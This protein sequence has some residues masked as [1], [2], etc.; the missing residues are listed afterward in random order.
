MKKILTFF[1]FLICLLIS[2]ENKSNIEIIKNPSDIYVNPRGGMEF[3]SYD[4]L[5]DYTTSSDEKKADFVL[6]SEDLINFDSIVPNSKIKEIYVWPYLGYEVRYSYGTEIKDDESGMS[7][8]TIYVQR[9]DLNEE[10]DDFLTDI[11]TDRCVD[12]K[13]NLCYTSFDETVTGSDAFCY[14]MGDYEFIVSYRN[15]KK[16]VPLSMREYIVDRIAIV[17]DNMYIEID[18]LRTEPF[19]TFTS[20]FVPQHGATDDTVI[21]MLDKIKALIPTDK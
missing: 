9:A 20:A 2:C 8:M 5:V 11:Y 3:L 10:H 13:K 21:A 12:L 18:G 16:N 15:L 6:S 4:E 19:S 7:P 1:I 14:S 17:I